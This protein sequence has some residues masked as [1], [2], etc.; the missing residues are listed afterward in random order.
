VLLVGTKRGLEDLDSAET[1]V[2]GRAVTALAAGPG[3]WHALL[4]RRLVIRLDSGGASTLGELPEPD[5]QSIAVLADGTVIVG[6]S[7]AR[8]AAIGTKVLDVP[9]FERVPG[10]DRWENP[11]GPTPDTRSMAVGSNELWVNVHVGGLW[12]SGDGGTTWRA[13]IEPGADV[14]EVRTGVGGTVAVAAAVGFGWSEDAG[15]AWSWTTEGL[16]ATYLRALSLDGDVAFVSASDGPFT[17]LAAVYRGQVGSAFT[18]CEKGLPE[19]FPGNVDT[20]HLDA[21]GGRVAFGFGE[22]VYLSEDAGRSWRT[23]GPLPDPVTAVRF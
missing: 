3:G 10:R 15:R 6:R 8:L 2:H 4:D 5:G 11:A 21:S 19:W 12:S 17:N 7:G 22:R 14:H 16:H 18:R 9:A 1:L 13:A 20:G 23:I